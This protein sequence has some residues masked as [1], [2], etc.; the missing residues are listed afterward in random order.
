MRISAALLLSSIAIAASANLAQAQVYATSVTAAEPDGAGKVPAFNAVP[1]AA[2]PSWSNGLA[3][4]VLTH[5]QLYNYCVSLASG[6]AKGTA[7]V[8]F[9]IVRSGKVLQSKTIIAAKDFKVGAN[10]IWYYCS[11]Y[12]PLPTSPGV[13]QLVGEVTYKGTTA[14]AAVSSQVASSVLLR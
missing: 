9:R 3:Q 6:A 11:G 13:A 1:G 8:S 10:G 5:G 2:I 7:T 4:G 14:K 12:L